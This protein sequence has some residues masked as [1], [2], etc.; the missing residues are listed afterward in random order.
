MQ[1]THQLLRDNY[2]AFAVNGLDICAYEKQR[3]V[4]ILYS[5]LSIVLDQRVESVAQLHVLVERYK[6]G[7]ID[8][9]IEIES[10]VRPH[11]PAILCLGSPLVS[12][13]GFEYEEADPPCFI[14][15]AIDVA[16]RPGGRQRSKF[17]AAAIRAGAI[18]RA[19]DHG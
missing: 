17:S 18:M 2:T 9:P 15:T 16:S 13:Y 19:L 10:L 14:V 11:Y 6:R 8:L 5:H 12:L 4:A 3:E 7:M 1:S